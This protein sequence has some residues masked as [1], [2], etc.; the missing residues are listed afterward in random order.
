M[1]NGQVHERRNRVRP[2][3]D[4]LR[5]RAHRGRLEPRRP[6]TARTAQGRRSR[7]EAP[8]AFLPSRCTARA[9]TRRAPASRFPRGRVLLIGGRSD[10][11]V[12]E[13]RYAQ[14]RLDASL[15]VA[16]GDRFVARSYSPVH[17][18]GGESVLAGKPQRRTTLSQ[19][20][21]AL[22]DALLKEAERTGRVVLSDGAV[23]HPSAAGGA[24][25][26]QE[27]ADVPRCA[28]CWNP[29]AA[30]RRRSPKT[31][32][33]LRASTPCRCSS[34][35]TTAASPCATATCDAFARCGPYRKPSRTC[36]HCAFS[37]ADRKRYYTVKLV[38]DGSHTEMNGPGGPRG[39][40]SRRE[41]RRAS[42]ACSIRTHLRHRMSE[43]PRIRTRAF[44]IYARNRLHRSSRKPVQ[45]PSPRSH[46]SETH[47]DPAEA[48]PSSLG[49]KPMVFAGR[50]YTKR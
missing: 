32:R 29:R 20:E 12:G 34:S 40:Q 38:I 3:G 19:D 37:V 10:L 8:G 15:P 39:L 49:T 14:I 17:V 43:R 1:T 41:A 33:A 50:A 24:T 16:S 25:A 42:R 18:I 44:F 46:V 47:E 27:Q 21:T 48:R 26:A 30:R 11:N 36:A 31:P 7:G 45:T 6:R 5:R 23:S 13:S 22:L 9:S 28:R 35:W 4:A 2:G